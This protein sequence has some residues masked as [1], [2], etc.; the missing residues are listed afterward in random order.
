[1]TIFGSCLL[2][3]RLVTYYVTSDFMSIWRPKKFSKIP[4]E[5]P[6][7]SEATHSAVLKVLGKHKNPIACP[8]CEQLMK[9]E[10]K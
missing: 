10:R 7:A 2:C 5:A 1:M 4:S 3:D 9:N 6:M 8:E